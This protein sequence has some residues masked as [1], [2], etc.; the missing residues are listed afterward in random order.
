MLKLN[1]PEYSFRIRQG[2]KG[3]QIF[4]AIRKKF[5][6]LTPEEWVRQN[7]IQYLIEEKKYPASLIAVETG[8]KYNKLQK[9]SDIKIHNR[10]GN[11]WMIVECKKPDVKISQE[12]FNQVAVYNISNKLRTKFLAVTNGLKHYCCE[13]NYEQGK[14]LFLKDFPEYK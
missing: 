8:L 2:E 1:L 3:N 11:V 12:T 10:K 4:D 6:A 5:V 7:F 14:H 13:M 9:R